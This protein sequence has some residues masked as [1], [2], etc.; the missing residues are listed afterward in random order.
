METRLER[1]YN[2]LIEAAWQLRPYAKKPV[3]C[4]NTPRRWASSL[5]RCNSLIPAFARRC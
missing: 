3:D 4:W 5:G 2:R 1:F